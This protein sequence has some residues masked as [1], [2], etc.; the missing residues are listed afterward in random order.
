[1]DASGSYPA[2]RTS[3]AT[4]G[5]TSW[6]RA[7][8]LFWFGVRAIAFWFGVLSLANVVGSL[9]NPAFDANLWWIDLRSFPTLFGDSLIAMAGVLLL[10][11]AVRPALRGFR[12][13]ASLGAIVVLITG[14][15]INTETYYRAW[16]DH[17]IAPRTALPL[18][19]LVA[20]LLGTIGLAMLH[21]CAPAT[22]IGRTSVIVAAS[23]FFVVG[24]PLLQ[25]AFFGTTDYRQPAQAVV[26]FGAQ[27]E[28][29]GQASIALADRVATA[30]ALY[31]EGLA[32]IVIMSGGTEP[33][34]YDETLVMRDL[35]EAEGV[36][37]NAIILDHGGANTQATVIDTANIFGRRSIDRVLVVS[38]FYHLPRIKLAY[39]AAGY[40]VWT[41]PAR[42]TP[43]KQTPL[44]V[45]REIPAFWL[46]YLRASLG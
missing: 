31:R 34:G 44:L 30:T 10:G 33:S 20:A 23:A 24:L 37:A 40:D 6:S 3:R 39:A 41:V 46:Y 4:F 18:S 21:P 9:R 43:I 42:D 22:R 14:A 12:L 36:P 2:S 11:F 19:L 32:P 16:S 7:G 15:L 38:Q 26:V 8:D 29:D 35:A 13:W 45:A 28:P 1:V 25:V 5:R 27:V 17:A